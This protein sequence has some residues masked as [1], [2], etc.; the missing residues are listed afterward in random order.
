[1]RVVLYTKV[2]F[3]FKWKRDFANAL[4]VIV[5]LPLR[6]RLTIGVK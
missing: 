2:V 1:M 4:V 5:S 3:G 6:Y